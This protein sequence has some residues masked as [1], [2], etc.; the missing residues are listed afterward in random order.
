MDIRILLEVLD[1]RQ[2]QYKYTGPMEGRYM[3]SRYRTALILIWR[4]CCMFSRP[5]PIP[6][7]L[8]I[9]VSLRGKQIFMRCC[10]RYF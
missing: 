10:R 5:L 7:R 9:P 4:G 2:N 8:K 6:A 1:T 3:G